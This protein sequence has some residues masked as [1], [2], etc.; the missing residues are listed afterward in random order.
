MGTEKKLKSS[1]GFTLVELM[2]ATFIFTFGLVA[3]V[4]SVVSMIGQQQYSD[5][6][7]ITSNYMNFILED[8]QEGASING[9]ISSVSTYN[10]PLDGNAPD[11]F[12]DGGVEVQIPELGTVTVELLQGDGGPSAKSVDIQMTMSLIAHDGR[13]IEKTSSRIITY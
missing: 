3:I 9:D 13:R 5:Y 4:S 10:W 1:D 6:D 2:V 12:T 11:L 8:L 7:T